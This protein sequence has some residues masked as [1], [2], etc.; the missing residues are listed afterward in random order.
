MKGKTA[1]RGRLK[2]ARKPAGEMASLLKEL[3]I[4]RKQFNLKEFKPHYLKLR[5]IFSKGKIYGRRRKLP[6]EIT[7]KINRISKERKSFEKSME[8]ELGAFWLKLVVSSW[9]GKYVAQGF[10]VAHLKKFD[11]LPAP[12][13]EKL[14]LGGTIASFVA[15]LYGLRAYYGA[16][17]R[18]SAKIP[19]KVKIDSLLNHIEDLNNLERLKKGNIEHPEIKKLR[20]FAEGNFLY[21]DREGNL[22][23]TPYNP[24]FIAESFG[25]LRFLIEEPKPEKEK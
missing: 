2:D 20:E 19:V 18:L 8:N 6:E 22:R 14:V 1:I 15:T 16:Y 24:T 3:V 17:P 12:W 9:L 7:E 10:K 13:K 25:A 23:A 4:R 21:V 5:E 11:T